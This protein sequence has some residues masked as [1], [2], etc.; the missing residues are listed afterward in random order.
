VAV[1]V[2]DTDQPV[3]VPESVRVGGDIKAPTKIKNVAPVYPQIAKNAGTQGVVIIEAKIDPSGIVAD[4]RILRSVPS[5]DVAAL[6]AVMQWKFT[7]TLLNG[8]PVPVIMTVTTNFVLDSKPKTTGVEGGVGPGLG[9]GVWPGVGAGTG[10]NVPGGVIGG[11]VGSLP[12]APPPPPPSE[13]PRRVGGDIS[14]PRKIKDVPPV[15]PA[16]ALAAKVQGVV[17]IEAVIGKD[18]KVESAK[19]VRSI[20]MLDQ[21][22]LDAVQQWEFT[23]TLVNGV[24]VPVVMTVTVNFKLQ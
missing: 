1:N 12:Q 14:A 3:S 16:E 9:A 11:V 8:V 20:P 10:S 17:I 24:A 5:L 22:A 21:A 15:Y 7:P 13:V 23:P 2:V 19:I 18:G 4:G 6:D